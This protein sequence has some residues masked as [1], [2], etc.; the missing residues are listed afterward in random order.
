MKNTQKKKEFTG[1]IEQLFLSSTAFIVGIFFFANSFQIR[2]PLLL[3]TMAI[4][5][6]VISFAIALS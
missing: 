4:V 2:Q 3:I 1:S 5:F 6:T